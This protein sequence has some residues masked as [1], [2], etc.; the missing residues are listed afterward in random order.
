MSNILENV[1][2]NF[3]WEEI[4][5]KPTIIDIDSQ[6]GDISEQAYNRE[7]IRLLSDEVRAIRFYG[8]QAKY[9]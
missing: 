4:G 8:F 9:T 7:G 1:F 3:D 2:I 6:I 5:S